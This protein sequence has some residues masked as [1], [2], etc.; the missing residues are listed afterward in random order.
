M[1]YLFTYLSNTGVKLKLCIYRF[2]RAKYITEREL[3]KRN[4][5]KLCAYTGVLIS[6]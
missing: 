2:D 4:V 3:N 1:I 6:P 5:R